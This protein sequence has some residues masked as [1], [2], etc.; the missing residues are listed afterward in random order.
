MCKRC[1]TKPIYKLSNGRQF[2]SKCFTRYYERKVFRTIKQ[3]NLIQKADKIAVAASG[4]KDST[5]L[6][7]LLKKFCRGGR[8]CTIEAVAIDEGIHA[9]RDKTLKDLR[10]FCKREKIKLHIFSYKKEFGFS[11]DEALKL[12]RERKI[13]LTS[14]NICGVLRRY[15]IN[16]KSRELGF[17]KVATGHNLDDEA[18]T[19][20]MNQFKGNI[21]LSAKLGPRS[22]VSEES[23]FAQRIKPL[24]FCTEKENMIYSFVHKIVPG[25]TECPNQQSYRFAIRDFLNKF[26]AQN[27]GVKQ[28]I[29]QSFLEVLPSLKEKFRPSA[30]GS[31]KESK[32][33]KQI[34]VLRSCARCG[35]PASN[36]V[37]KACEILGILEAAK[38]NI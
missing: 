25:F 30:D 18:Q 31:K 37:C 35:E 6:L 29:V 27:P 14:C 3:Y 28:A 4:G 15:L 26:E 32:S 34:N 7:F 10:A 11:L 33:G 22:G 9:Y 5:T 23:V 36:E 12:V 38:K 13:K 16:K 1:E 21:S 8:F 2:C 20:L 19:I 24:Y 17:A